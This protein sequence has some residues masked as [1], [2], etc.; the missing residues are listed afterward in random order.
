MLTVRQKM[1]IETDLMEH[2]GLNVFQYKLLV[3]IQENEKLWNQQEK[4]WYYSPRGSCHLSKKMLAAK[5]SVKPRYV[6]NAIQHL[7]NKK[8]FNLL[9]KYEKNP[10]LIATNLRWKE[11]RAEAEKNEI[12]KCKVIL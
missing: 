12:Q 8:G 1:L 10:S 4:K 6:F 5:L 3:T 7:L 2:F 11:L 9:D